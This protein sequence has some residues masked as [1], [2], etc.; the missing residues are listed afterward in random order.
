MTQREFLE[1]VIATSGVA[2]EV[3]TYAE[4]KI[5][6]LNAKNTNRSSKPTKKQ[7][8]NEPIKTKILEYLETHSQ[9][10]GTDLA[11]AINENKSR[12]I[13]LCTILAK[14]GKIVKR[15]ISIPSVGKRMSYTL[16]ATITENT[17]GT[18]EQNE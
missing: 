10:I 18:E 6:S 15:E 7:L 17:E 2:E 1:Q 4:T 12:V 3:K 5:E 8:E 16:A 13:S 14:E 11:A 9:V